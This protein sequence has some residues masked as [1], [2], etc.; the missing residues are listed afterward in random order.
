MK[1]TGFLP[2]LALLAFGCGSNTATDRTTDTP[3]S[4]R[5][6]MAVDEGYRPVIEAELD[7][8][9]SIY[10]QAKIDA[11]YLPENEAVKL[12]LDDSLEVAILSRRL[13]AEEEKYFQSKGFTPKWTK[14]AWDGLAVI[15]NPAN[16]D[17][18]L[19]VA[20][21]A[22]IL[23][24]KVTKWAKIDPKST[25][26]AIQVVFDNPNSGLVRFAKDSILRGAALSPTAFALKN[27]PEVIRHVAAN[28]GAIGIIGLNWLS[29][30]DDQGVQKFRKEI[31]LAEMLEAGAAGLPALSS[32]HRAGRLPFPCCSLLHQRAG[33]GVRAGFGRCVVHRQPARAANCL[34][35]RTAAGKRAAAAGGGEARI[36]GALEVSRTWAVA[37][38]TRAQTRRPGLGT[39][40]AGPRFLKV[41]GYSPF[42]KCDANPERG[43]TRRAAIVTSPTKPSAR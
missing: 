32:L 19:T 16:R 42:C 37:P 35:E 21:V 20:Q 41:C 1:K 3:T 34:E 11:R 6:S 8:F 9:D 26:G 24:G 10:G 43:T 39:S 13:N 30:T 28:K 31:R 14:L 36:R 38:S 15:L 22:D 2:L 25:L 18:T 29:D 12:L 7:V 5:I 4:G 40:R 27:N 23:S 33:P 17:T